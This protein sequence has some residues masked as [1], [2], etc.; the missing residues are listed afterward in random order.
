MKNI[1]ESRTT[2]LMISN[3]EMNYIKKM[4]KFLEDSGILLKR[5]S[6][7]IENERKENNKAVSLAFCW[8]I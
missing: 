5:V 1:I 7:A 4:I 8:M 3:E 2:T 6:E